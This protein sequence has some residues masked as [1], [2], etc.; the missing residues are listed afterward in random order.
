MDTDEPHQFPP[1]RDHLRTFDAKKLQGLYHEITAELRYRLSHQSSRKN[2]KF[3]AVTNYELFRIL[4]KILDKV[5]H[6]LFIAQT[7]RDEIWY[8]NRNLNRGP[9]ILFISPGL[10]TAH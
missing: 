7:S 2:P 8:V 5:M 9:E 4:N 3:H 1:L 6:I 10:A